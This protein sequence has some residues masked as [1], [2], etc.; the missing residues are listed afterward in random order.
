VKANVG[1]QSAVEPKPGMRKADALVD[2]ATGF[3]GA[4]QAMGFRFEIDEPVVPM[5]LSA[6]NGGDLHNIV[7]VFSDRALKIPELPQKFVQGKISGEKLFKNM[8]EP[9]PVKVLGGTIEDAE[10]MGYFKMPQYNRDPRPKNGDA[11]D[12]LSSD[13]LAVKT[14]EL[15][16]PFE[17]REK[18]LLKIGERLGLRG[19]EVDKLIG[20]VI[21]KERLA[22]AEAV[23]DAYKGMV[24]TV[25]KGDFPREVI[26]KQNLHFEAFDAKD[27]ELAQVGNIEDNASP[28]KGL[29]AGGALAL[30]CG[31]FLIRRQAV[32]AG[33]GGLLVMLC[34]S[35]GVHD[36]AAAADDSKSVHLLIS[37]MSE[38]ETSEAAAATLVAMGD[39]ALMDLIGEAVE[40][41]DYNRRGWAIA[42]LADIGSKGAVKSLTLV[43]DDADT[44]D[45]VKMWAGA[46]L[47]RIRGVD[48]IKDLMRA[49]AQD[50][51]KQG[52][53]V[54]LLLGMRAGAV[55]P[56]TTIM[57]TGETNADR[58]QATA[59]LGT[60]D[61]RL[62]G[63]IVKKVL[64]E[65]LGYSVEQAGKGV[66]W[67]GGALYLPRTEWSAPQA[68]DMSRQL[69]CWML[70][71]EENGKDE[72]AK[73]VSNNLR[74]LS[75]RNGI[76]FRQG[77]SG[78]DWA[79]AFLK[80]AGRNDSAINAQTDTATV[81]LIVQLL[82]FA[83]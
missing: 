72:L 57:L 25:I 31:V 14:G 81:I 26:A 12:L 63:G 55:R 53:L 8:T 47:T 17:A 6:F 24:L 46:A 40:G 21:S 65:A 28:G 75:W 33:A 45:L 22:A 51:S 7:Y 71:A 49:A 4:E 37:A 36:S 18:E 54:G 20:E 32:G 79:K 78:I 58:Q 38:P 15:T 68:W 11:Y 29:M 61:Q 70:W 56:L 60:L 3:E 64:G 59:W 1:S 27:L 5:R 30:L 43:S 10:K 35:I 34:I 50:S 9:L 82:E 66:P 39:K 42:C 2:D 48:A 62:R 52:A 13:L 67:E 73:Q 77:G 41:D 69:I 19:E 23:K 16:H 74:D 83:G 76:G 44:P 80:K